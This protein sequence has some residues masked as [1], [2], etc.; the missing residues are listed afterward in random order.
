MNN[1]HSFGCSFSSVNFKN[2]CVED[3][4]YIEYKLYNELLA[5]K[6]NLNLICSSYEGRGNN[7][8]ILD[9]AETDFKNTSLVIIQ[10]TFPH[11][12]E[13]RKNNILDDYNSDTITQPITSA[14]LSH[15]SHKGITE[16]HIETYIN[17]VDE[18]YDIL[19]FTDIYNITNSINKKQIKYPNCK[20]LLIT[21][22]EIKKEIFKNNLN[23]YK[24]INL[25]G[26]LNLNFETWVE[27][28]KKINDSRYF[29]DGHLSTN[30]NQKLYENI[31][32]IIEN[33]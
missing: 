28:G 1:L 21:P 10:L 9:F 25:N 24:N 20:F 32:N 16:K 8:I 30:G 17:F 3:R 6:L 11:R 18:W 2:K 15:L 19:A 13:F 33:E 4:G 26:F 5:E 7:S 29:K 22:D 14:T 12:I 23:L 31:L 27:Y